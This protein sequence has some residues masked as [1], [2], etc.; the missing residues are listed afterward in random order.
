MLALKRRSLSPRCSPRS[1]SGRGA[2]EGREASQHE[3]ATHEERLVQA[4]PCVIRDATNARRLSAKPGTPRMVVITPNASRS[5]GRRTNARAKSEETHSVDAQPDENAE[6]D[7]L[8]AFDSWRARRWRR[9]PCR[10]P[11]AEQLGVSFG[12]PARLEALEDVLLRLVLRAQPLDQGPRRLVW[13]GLPHARRIAGGQPRRAR[14]SDAPPALVEGRRRHNGGREA[15]HESARVEWHDHH[16][17][18]E[19]RRAECLA[20]RARLTA[21]R[22]YSSATRD[23]SVARPDPSSTRR[24]S[25]SPGGSDPW[26]SLA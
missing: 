21:N 16:Q 9:A 5:P 23:L 13:S 14:P 22:R 25:N 26:R 6:Q 1:S 10:S 17:R 7:S 24:I 12:E 18:V 3:R 19:T 20:R 4:T 11:H 8:L 2:G 15:Q